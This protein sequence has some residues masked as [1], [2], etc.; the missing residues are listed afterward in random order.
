VP[1]PGRII[2]EEFLIFLTSLV[3]MKFILIRSNANFKDA[4]LDP[5][6]SMIATCFFTTITNPLW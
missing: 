6:E 3:T 2:C 1:T 5:I 4:R